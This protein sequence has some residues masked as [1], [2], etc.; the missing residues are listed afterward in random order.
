M[1]IDI[2]LIEQLMRLLEASAVHELELSEDGSR[3]R[4]SKGASLLAPTPAATAAVNPPQTVAAPVAAATPVSSPAPAAGP[5]HVVRAGLSGT[6]YRA[7]LPG[8][9]PFVQIGS[10][11]AEGGKLAIIEAMKMMN[12]VEAEVD[13][14]VRTIHVEDGAPVEPGTALFTLSLSA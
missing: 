4:L 10:R 13:G 8:E 6:F 9:A 1:A 7:P 5:E 11:I 2:N 14:V 3:I 12:P